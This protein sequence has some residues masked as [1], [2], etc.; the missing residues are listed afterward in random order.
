MIY[1]DMTHCKNKVPQKYIDEVLEANKD[2]DGVIHV[3]DND[4][5]DEGQEPFS[6][7]RFAEGDFVRPKKGCVRVP[8]DG[9][10]DSN[11]SQIWKVT[12]VSPATYGFMNICYKDLKT[13]ATGMSYEGD[14]EPMKFRKAY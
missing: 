13:G 6:L 3:Y 7:S 11:E 4:M 1:L 14:L 5:V 12:G 2:Y 8:E 10:D 9:N